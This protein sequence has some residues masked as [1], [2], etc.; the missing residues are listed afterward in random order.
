MIQAL[1]AQAKS[2]WYLSAFYP[3]KAKEKN[4]ND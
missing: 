1:T 3:L 4:E 2:L